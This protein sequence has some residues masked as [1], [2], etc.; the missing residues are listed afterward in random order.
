MS[1]GNS[2]KDLA[3]LKTNLKN[4][5]LLDNNEISFQLQPENGLLIDDFLEN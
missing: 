4:T 5:I 1:N 2:F 3:K